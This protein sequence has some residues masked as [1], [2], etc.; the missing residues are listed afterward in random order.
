MI[1]D[2]EAFLGSAKV[3]LMQ[4]VTVEDIKHHNSITSLQ[5]F[6]SS[7]AQHSERIHLFY[8]QD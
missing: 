7:N 2:S 6:H 8:I 4:R 5:L 1:Q 3:C